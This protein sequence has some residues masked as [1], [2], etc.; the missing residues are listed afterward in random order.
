MNKKTV[1]RS[2]WL[3]TSLAALIMTLTI[4]FGYEAENMRY[5]ILGLNVVA[6]AL[7][8]PSSLI[9]VP[10]AFAANYY[11]DINALSTDGIYLNTFFLLFVGGAQWF[12]ITNVF[13]SFE[14]RMQRLE[15]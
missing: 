7:S 10:V 1:L 6:F 11:L 14:S 2:L 15:I 9:V 13:Q 5:V 4:W 12:L 3:S 8:V